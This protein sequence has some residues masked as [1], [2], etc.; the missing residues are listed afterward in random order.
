MAL[1]GAVFLS[2]SDS[3]AEF[4]EK[5]AAQSREVGEFKV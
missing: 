3:H 2:R 4:S 1:S 5:T